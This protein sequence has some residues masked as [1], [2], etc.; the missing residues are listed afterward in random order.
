MKMVVSGLLTCVMA[1]SPAASVSVTNA[2]DGDAGD[3]TRIACPSYPTC[4]KIPACASV[5]KAK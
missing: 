1:F 3:S 4:K 5:C 2:G